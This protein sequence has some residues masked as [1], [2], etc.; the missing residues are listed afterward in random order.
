MS[1]NDVPIGDLGYPGE[2]GPQFSLW[3]YT[4][5]GWCVAVAEGVGVPVLWTAD[6]YV[7]HDKKIQSCFS[8]HADAVAILQE[9]RT[10]FRRIQF[11]DYFDLTHKVGLI[12]L[13]VNEIHCIVVIRFY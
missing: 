11:A 9:K 13:F 10:N 2:D 3:S 1:L 6:G 12:S 4:T 5:I 8:L 7:S